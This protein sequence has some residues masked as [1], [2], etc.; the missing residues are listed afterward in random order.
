[1][2]RP[3]FLILLAGLTGIEIQH[4]L[5]Q[6]FPTDITATSVSTS[7]AA[8]TVTASQESS[9]LTSSTT[10]SNIAG[11]SY[12]SASS[13]SE[14]KSMSSTSTH[15]TPMSTNTSGASNDIASST[16]MEDVKSNG[17]G[18]SSSAKLGVGIGMGVGIPLLAVIFTAI[19]LIRKRRKQSALEPYGPVTT[20]DKGVGES[21]S[22]HSPSTTPYELRNV[23]SKA[24]F[25]PPIPAQGTSLQSPG[26]ELS[27]T[28]L[29]DERSSPTAP[30][31]HD[32]SSTQRPATSQDISRSSTLNLHTRPATAPQQHSTTVDDL[33][34]SPVS[35]IS[36]VSPISAA[37]SRPSSLRHSLNHE[38]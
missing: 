38:R 34:P 24:P 32:A 15:S 18:L 29:Q 10:S 37:S 27:P 5:A 25:L 16:S 2:A 33:P 20:N 14:T 9:T 21:S 13:A 30:V 12:L 22:F 8:S 4:A 26:Q 31:R 11:V 17:S 6:R 7:S 19:F 3:A 1:M 23:G 36:S 35:P 28:T